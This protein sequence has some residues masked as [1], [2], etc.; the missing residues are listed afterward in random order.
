MTTASGR[1]A[2][3]AIAAHPDD[4]EFMMAGALLRLKEAGAEIHLWN[5]CTG[6]CGTETMDTE[7]TIRVRTAEARASAD[8]AGATIHPPMANDLELL[9]DVEHVRRVAAVI[10]EVQPSILL[11]HN[12]QDYME[13]HQNACRIAVT[14][15]FSKAMRNFHFIPASKPWNGDLV[16]YHALPH[17]LCDP[18]RQPIQP[19]L[20]V[21]VTPV[22]ETKREMLACHR[23]QKEWLDATQGMDSYL[24]LMVEQC[25]EVGRRSGRFEYAEAYR[26][27]LNIGFAA[28][29]AD[30][31][32]DRLGE[33]VRK[34]PKFKV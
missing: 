13:D 24:N 11:T 12:P 2:A 30:P 5:L 3:M 10:R 8:L 31:L 19:E 28:E 20:Y 26:R 27:H 17:S 25:R 33:A 18:L 21:D 34:D 14:A 4:I 1:W 9:Y 6:N 15:A 23:S 32:S 22:I 7:E 16:V 29:H